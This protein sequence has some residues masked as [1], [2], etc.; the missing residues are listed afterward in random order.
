MTMNA[1]IHI[2]QLCN[3]HR[4]LLVQQCEYGPADSWRA[5]EIATTIAL[6]QGMSA[7]PRVHEES[8]GDLAK[9][10]AI[11]CPACRK[12]DLFGALVHRVQITPRAEQIGAIKKLGEQWVTEAT[13]GKA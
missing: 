13:A 11:G 3:T 6:F 1:P 9:V 7:D 8:N 2:P 12:P 5:L 4:T 10:A